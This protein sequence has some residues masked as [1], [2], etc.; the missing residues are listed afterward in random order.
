[1]SMECTEFAELCIS[2][3]ALNVLSTD[4]K[5]VILLSLV[6]KDH[7]YMPEDFNRSNLARLMSYSAMIWSTKYSY[8][9]R[10]SERNENLQFSVNQPGNLLG[11]AIDLNFESNVKSMGN[12]TVK[13]YLKDMKFTVSDSQGTRITEGNSSNLRNM[14]GNDIIVLSSPNKLLMGQRY[15]IK[16]TSSNTPK[17]DVYHIANLNQSDL[18]HNSA[19]KDQP[20][21]QTFGSVFNLYGSYSLA[22]I[23]G[24]I[25]DPQIGK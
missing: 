18:L 24:I 13:N 20:T 19:S 5:H 3:N 4:E 21:Q 14:N 11:F 15:A 17:Y 12:Y 10:C 1:M 25:F 7:K 6:L 23:V 2:P 16:C 8:E 22:P 9:P